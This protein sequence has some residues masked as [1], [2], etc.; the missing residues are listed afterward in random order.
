MMSA[1]SVADGP[2]VPDLDVTD[3]ATASAV[4][5]ALGGELRRTREARGWSRGRFVQK[6]PSKIGDRTLLSYEHG[7]RHMTVLRLVELSQAL[8]VPASTVVDQALQRARLALVNLVLRVDL[9]QLLEDRSFHYRPM[10]PWARNRL[11]DSPNG[12]IEVSPDGVRELAAFL[13]RTPVEVSAYLAQFIPDDAT[14]ED[15]GAVVID[16]E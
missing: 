10:R 1:E 6:L 9:R 3:E 2:C 4:A 16:G 13:G 14:E 7:I 12:I 15:R 5:R 11:N 8:K